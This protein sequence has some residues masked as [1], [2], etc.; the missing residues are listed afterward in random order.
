M[1]ESADYTNRDQ[2]NCHPA[3]E[4]MEVHIVAIFTPKPDKVDRVSALRGRSQA[5]NLLIVP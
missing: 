1:Q 4:I 5:P 2:R 3:A